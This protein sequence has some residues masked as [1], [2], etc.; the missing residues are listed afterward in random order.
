VEV[1]F[2][3]DLKPL[4]EVYMMKMCTLLR[5]EAHFEVKMRKTHHAQS[6]FGSALRCG[7]KH[8]SKPK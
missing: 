1:H 3:G 6:T 8:I 7:A 5:R 4:L 2:S